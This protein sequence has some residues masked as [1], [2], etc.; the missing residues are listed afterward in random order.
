MTYRTEHL[1]LKEVLVRDCIVRDFVLLFCFILVTVSSENLSNLYSYYKFGNIT[2]VCSFS[3]SARY[4]EDMTSFFC[5][6]NEY[7]NDYKVISIR[8]DLYKSETKTQITD[9]HR[10]I[11]N[12]IRHI[13]IVSFGK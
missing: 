12:I 6:F 8:Q 10:I 5:N 9:K 13:N 4:P 2:S 11:L 3:L 1:I 7:F